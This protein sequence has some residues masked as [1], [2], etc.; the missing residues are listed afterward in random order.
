MDR[1]P[2]NLYEMYTS[3]STLKVPIDISVPARLEIPAW[4]MEIVGRFSP[5]NHMKVYTNKKYL[6][7]YC[8]EVHQIFTG[9]SCIVA[10]LNAFMHMAILHSVFEGSQI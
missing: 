3:I 1:S 6:T 7:G 4:R 10:G 9:Y 2:P 5:N 8:T